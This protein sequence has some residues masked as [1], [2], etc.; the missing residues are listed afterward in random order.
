MNKL[1]MKRC[2][3]AVAAACLAVS[4]QAGERED[5]ELV[6]QT[7]TNLIDALVDQGVLPRKAADDLIQKAQKKAVATV[8][9]QKAQ[10]G[11]TV[12]VTYVPESVKAEMREQIKQEV[13]AQ[14]KNERWGDPGTLPEWMDRI[15]WEGD[16]RVRYQSDNLDRA[17]SPLSDYLADYNSIPG[18]TRY[19][20]AAD[21]SANVPSAFNVS[22][23]RNRLRVRARLGVLAK[24][25]PMVSA[26][27][28]LATGNTN[29]RVSTNQD[30]GGQFNK[31]SA[32]F[33]RAYLRLNP[34][35]S[36]SISAGRMP[37]PWFG[38]DLVWDED[39]NFEGIAATFKPS[40]SPSFAPFVTLGAFPL[41]VDSP[42]AQSGNRWLYGAQAGAQWDLA[43]NTRSKFS[44]GYFD[45]RNLEGKVIPSSEYNGATYTSNNSRRYEYANGFRQK[46]NTLFSTNATGD[47][48][49]A[50]IWGL[51][52]KFQ[53]L[54]ITGSLDLA[55][56]DPVHLV[57]TGDF[58][59]N[60][61][62]DRNEI[63]RRTQRQF[64]D[65][66]DVG[67]QIKTVIGM[68]RVKETRDWQVSFAYRRLGS[69]A[70]LDAFT[71]SDYN[72][73]GTNHKGYVLGFSYGIDRNTV[74]GV[75]W[76]SFDSID[77]PTFAVPNG[78]YGSDTLMADV[79]ASF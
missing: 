62:F 55:R 11:K 69:D 26:G 31:Y 15:Q 7:T 5:L 75:R 51:A 25:T 33:D 46:G 8:A 52:S 65:G 74:L 53:V 44:V 49:V 77:S 6:R 4:A 17:N 79:T 2:V 14:A 30:M 48:T 35:E 61:G 10:E 60:L 42:P 68:P 1:S 73:G 71:D 67:W 63:V 9:A 64:S 41:R 70:V 50:P 24:V 12:R 66:K 40:V 76:M 57:I 38:T 13:L 16:V 23:N 36:L 18:T 59:K 27:V 29:E 37:N 58:A 56:W 20:D 34:M 22:D 21:G 45:F 43:S 72:L 28:R 78:R 32:W 39:L 47:N 19:G 3:L 54:N